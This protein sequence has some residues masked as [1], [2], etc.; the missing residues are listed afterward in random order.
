MVL[1]PQFSLAQSCS[2]VPRPSP[3]SSFDSVQYA[4]TN[5]EKVG[6]AGARLSGRGWSKA[7][8]IHLP[9]ATNTLKIEN[10]VT[11]AGIK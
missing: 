4:K 10:V 7:K 3:L 8:Y 11:C 1:I 6:G 9:Q 5:E 2:L